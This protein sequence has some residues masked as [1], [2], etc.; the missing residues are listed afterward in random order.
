MDHKIAYELL[1]SYVFGILEE[2]ERA[3]VEAHLND[4]CTVCSARLREVSE[5]SVRLAAT[6]PQAEPPAHVK[7]R[8]MAR[9]GMT[10][11]PARSRQ[12]AEGA[13]P[14][15]W[16]RVAWGTAAVAVAAAGFL[17]WQTTALR[18]QV[19]ET[20]RLLAATTE[21]TNRMQNE[22]ASLRGELDKYRHAPVLGEPGVRFVSLDGMEPNRQAFGNVVTRPDKSAGMLYVYRFPMAPEDKEYQLWGLRDGKPPI[23]LGMFSVNTDGTAMLNMETIPAGE[24]IVGFSVTIEPRGGMPEPTGMMYVKGMDPMEED[25]G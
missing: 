25:G 18:R 10:H 14:G 24:E 4:G 8:L 5:L 9:V 17:L 3:A 20:N 11:H 6:V 1:D 22:V 16:L 23:S 2:G 12:R 7:E 15:A 21:N 19:E 13:S